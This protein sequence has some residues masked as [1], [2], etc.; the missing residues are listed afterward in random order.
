VLGQLSSLIPSQRPTQLLRQGEDRAHDGVAHRFGAMF[1]ESGAILLARSES[2]HPDA[3]AISR[4]SSRFED[5]LGH[6]VFERKRSGARLTAG[7]KT[8]LPHVRRALAEME[9]VRS[10]GIRKRCRRGQ[11]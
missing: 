7:G 1:G 11:H 3:D 9:S 6:T 10:A 8:I 5:A 2:R 4:R